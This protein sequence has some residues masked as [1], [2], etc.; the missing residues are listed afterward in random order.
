[1]P[2]YADAAELTSLI[3]EEA[4]KT[5]GLKVL[6]AQDEAE[7]AYKTATQELGFIFPEDDDTD[8]G[9]KCLWLKERMRRWY[10]SRLWDQHP[11]RFDTSDMKASQ[12]VANLEKR[13]KKLDE[14]F[15]K[16][17]EDKATAHLFIDSSMVIGT[18][19]L[20]TPSGFEDDRVGTDY[21]QRNA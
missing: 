16:A 10:M 7:E 21:E 19:L 5:K 12:V 6:F 1:M 8:Y 2:D 9:F 14:D 17:K 4:N 15:M 20:V 11:M 3:Q 13:V 18:T